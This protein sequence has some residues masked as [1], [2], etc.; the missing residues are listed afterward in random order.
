MILLPQG[1]TDHEVQADTASCSRAGELADTNSVTRLDFMPNSLSQADFAVVQELPEDVRADL[2]NVLPLHRSRDPT[3]STSNV[4][5]NK[6]LKNGATMIQ[7]I[8]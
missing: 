8:Q 5:E 6:S 7:K 4:T 1:T 2:F 3:C